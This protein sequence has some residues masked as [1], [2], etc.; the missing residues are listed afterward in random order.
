MTALADPYKGWYNGFSMDERR[1]VNPLLR[2]ARL[3]GTLNTP[4]KCSLCNV[5]KSGDEPIRIDW[6]LEDYR[7]YLNPYPVCWQCHRAIHSRFDRP[8]AWSCFVA[9]LPDISWGRALSL[10]PMST[11]RPFNDTYPHGVPQVND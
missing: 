8:A 5:E 4:S 11:Q 2:A 10:D 7:D 6:H 1:A 9:R 3:D